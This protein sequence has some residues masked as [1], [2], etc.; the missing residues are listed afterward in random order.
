MTPE[1]EGGNRLAH[2]QKGG[3]ATCMQNETTK[4]EESRHVSPSLPIRI[5]ERGS[6]AAGVERRSVATS[7]LAASSS[8]VPINSGKRALKLC[9]LP[10]P[11]RGNLTAESVLAGPFTGERMARREHQMPSVKRS[12]GKR[13]YFYIRYRVRVLVAGDQFERKEKQHF[14]G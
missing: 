13:P 4:P 12:G 6:I 14:L 5:D 1:L 7:N 9:V 2:V 8:P 10:P 3:D 11:S